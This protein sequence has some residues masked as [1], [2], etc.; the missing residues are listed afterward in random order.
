ML[1]KCVWLSH[2]AGQTAKQIKRDTQ[3]MMRLLRV[4]EQLALMIQNKMSENGLDFS[5]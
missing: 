1:G 4:N 3:T 2:Q 5:E